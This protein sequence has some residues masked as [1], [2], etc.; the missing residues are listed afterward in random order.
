[1]FMRHS[2]RQRGVRMC[3]NDTIY[4]FFISVIK[5]K[6]TDL[7]FYLL[8]KTEL[9]TC[10]CWALNAFFC[11]DRLTL[12][13]ILISFDITFELFKRSLKMSVWLVSCCGAAPCVWTLRTPIRNI[14]TYLN[15]YVLIYLLT[16]LE[17]G[18]SGGITVTIVTNIAI[19]KAKSWI[20]KETENRQK[21]LIRS[22]SPACCYKR[23]QIG[24]KHVDSRMGKVEA[25]LVIWTM[26]RCRTACDVT[27]CLF[28]SVERNRAPGTSKRRD[29]KRLQPLLLCK[30]SLSRCPSPRR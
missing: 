13:I 7:H 14:L 5:I 2:V 8:I 11:G 17:N 19:P 26:H 1:M 28:S 30:L 10:S 3:V 24:N 23:F 18:Q 12:D 22:L 27:R 20:A 4:P 25:V 6:R 21:Q 29:T 9:I 16:Y 15:T